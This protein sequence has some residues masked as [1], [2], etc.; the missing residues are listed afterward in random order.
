VWA[1][2]RQKNSA[3]GSPHRFEI[4]ERITASGYPRCHE[5]DPLEVTGKECTLV[6]AVLAVLGG[7]DNGCLWAIRIEFGCTL[8]NT[9]A[10]FGRVV[11]FNHRGVVCSGRGRERSRQCLV[12]GAYPAFRQ[13]YPQFEGLT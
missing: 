4:Y 2:L 9:G 7:G 1:V 3:G 13:A 8:D 6:G 11:V 5:V 12:A 10:R